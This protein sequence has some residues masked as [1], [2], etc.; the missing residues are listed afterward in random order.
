V[1]EWTRP[2]TATANKGG[3]AV[4]KENLKQKRMRQRKPTD[5]DYETKNDTHM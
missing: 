1:N 2:S 3:N 5:M 4:A